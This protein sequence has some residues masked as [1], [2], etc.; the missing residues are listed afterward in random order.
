MSFFFVFFTSVDNTDIEGIYNVR[1]YL[2]F[3]LIVCLLVIAFIFGSQNEQILTL[4]YFI[5]RAQMT[6]AAVVS[7]FTALG[8]LLGV[9]VTIFWRLIRKSKKVL[10]KRKLV[11]Q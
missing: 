3:F 7:L 4:N 1:L 8:F 2:T 9:L 5:A 11:E 10:T 6:V